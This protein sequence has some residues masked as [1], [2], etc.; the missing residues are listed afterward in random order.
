MEQ[1]QSQSTQ[2]ATLITASAGGSLKYRLGFSGTGQP[3]FGELR[4][5]Y[6][7]DA[8]QLA[9]LNTVGE[10]DATVTI[11]IDCRTVIDGRWYAAAGV[12][13]FAATALRNALAERAPKEIAVDAKKRQVSC[14]FKGRTSTDVRMMQM[15]CLGSHL[16]AIYTASF[17]ED[18]AVIYRAAAPSTA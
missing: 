5:E 18:V 6:T 14:R 2:P 12:C 1:T 13:A 15:F 7:C 17:F 4:I 11:I 8:E 3:C 9:E 16:L 10:C